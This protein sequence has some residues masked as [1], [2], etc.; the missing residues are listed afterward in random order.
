[1]YGYV[2]YEIPAMPAIFLGKEGVMIIYHVVDAITFFFDLVTGF[3][4]YKTYIFG[5]DDLVIAS[6]ILL[7]FEMLF[8]NLL[9][10]QKRM[11]QHHNQLHVLPLSSIGH[12]TKNGEERI[13]FQ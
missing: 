9:S 12:C 2:R 7:P 3:P 4:I 6:F 5:D 8:R 1:M 11:L 13:V 10:L